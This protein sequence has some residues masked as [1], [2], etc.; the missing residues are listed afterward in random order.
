MI[1]HECLQ[2]L[3]PLIKEQLVLTSQSGQRIEWSHLSNRDGNLLLGMMGCAIGVGM[4]LAICSKIAE[5]HGG[6]IWVDSEL[7]KGATFN[8]TLPIVST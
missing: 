2:F 3:A 4:G 6:K 7:G 8:F 1:R 5:Q